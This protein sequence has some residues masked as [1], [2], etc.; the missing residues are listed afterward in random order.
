ME[1]RKARY[2]VEEIKRL[3]TG[4]EIEILEHVAG[5]P[6]VVLD[7]SKRE[8]P[9]PKCDG[10]TRFRLIDAKAGAVRCSRCFAEGCGDYF[11]AVQ[12]MKGTDFAGALALI[13]DHLQATPQSAKPHSA[14]SSRKPL[15]PKTLTGTWVYTDE[16]GN[17]LYRVKRFDWIENGV[18]K[19]SIF[20]ERFENGKFVVGL[21]D[22]LKQAGGVPLY[23]P[24]IVKRKDEPLYIVEGEK[25]CDALIKLG[26]LATTASGGSN[27][28][29]LDW[30]QC[31]QGREV[32]ILPDQDKP[33]YGY[34]LAVADSLHRNNRVKVVFLPDLAEKE[35]IAD[36]I[37]RGGTRDELDRIVGETPI[38]DGQPFVYS[39]GEPEPKP[40]KVE[41]QSSSK[42]EITFVPKLI[43]PTKVECK[44]ISWLWENKIPLE[45]VTVF[46]GRQGGG[47]TFWSCYLAAVVTNGWNW[48]DG[49]ASPSGSALF[50]YGEDSIDKVFIP[51]LKAQGADL[52]KIRILDGLKGL[53]DGKEAGE[54]E[55]TLKAV[56]QIR[57]AICTT[58]A[59]TGQ[60]V[61]LVVVDPISNYWGGIKENDNTQVREVLRPIQRLAEE[62]GS[63]FLLIT[64][65][66]KAIKEEAADKVI[67]SIAITA[68]ARTVWHLYR[69][70]E[71]H[72][73]DYRCF[74][75]SKDNILVDAT[76]VEFLVNKAAGGRV[77]VVSTDLEKHANDIEA[78]RF[79]QMLERRSGRGR[80]PEQLEAAK[81]WLAG[82]LKDGRKPAGSR[83]DPQEGT[84]YYE[85]AQRGIKQRTLQ[86]AAKELGVKNIR[87]TSVYFWSIEE[88]EE[89]GELM[90]NDSSASCTLGNSCA[91][92]PHDLQGENDLFSRCAT[93]DAIQGASC[94]VE[95]PP[96]SPV[97][98]ERPEREVFTI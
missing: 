39:T 65:F 33:G 72:R 21:N 66:G 91:P 22:A 8:H 59:E 1:E 62:T 60:P 35:D 94:A 43:D 90:R 48:P 26:L 57:S 9:C 51:R 53:Q 6:R 38:W 75:P 16:A 25:C 61:R 98:E 11:A 55:I 81:E 50:F 36:W 56:D 19:K 82:F 4:R 76:G 28:N 86:A 18:K 7:N 87:E 71:P 12:W 3:A 41:K 44:P 88:I 67:G 96:P 73:K 92:S 68:S 29:R 34:A 37:E 58:E 83:D 84:V 40:A 23:L 97:P 52:S 63:A 79:A 13:G 5:I 77:E 15:I 20:Q 32:I 78:E 70:E 31:V 64:H 69:D 17:P 14:G 80:K 46:A 85:A 30:L 89:A 54:K 42:R 27:N 47:K 10:N 45:M 24:E 74:V 49:T 93:T 2:S 95:N